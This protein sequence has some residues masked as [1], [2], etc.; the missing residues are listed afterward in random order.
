M[1]RWISE[2]S[3]NVEADASVRRNG[4]RHDDDELLSLEAEALPRVDAGAGCV[5][6][7][8][9]QMDL[10]GMLSVLS[11]DT[12][13][14]RM[15]ALSLIAVMKAGAWTDASYMCLIAWYTQHEGLLV[16]AGVVDVPTGSRPR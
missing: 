16:Q 9:L 7:V 12:A 13:A 8:R 2:G 10:A 6:R 4:Y 14:F 1:P 3:D 5:I 11:I 15:V